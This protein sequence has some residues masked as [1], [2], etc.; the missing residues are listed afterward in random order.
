[1][2]D[3]TRALFHEARAR[4]GGAPRMPGGLSLEAIRLYQ[5]ARALRPAITAAPNSAAA[6]EYRGV[7]RKLRL[8]FDLRPWNE[9]ALMAPVDLDAVQPAD[10]GEFERIDAVRRQLNEACK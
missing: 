2:S 1:M 4:S 3:D 10:R 5:R 8:M 6:N 9:H 7:F